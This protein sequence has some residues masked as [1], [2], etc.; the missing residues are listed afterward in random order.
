[1]PVSTERRERRAKPDP[2]AEVLDEDSYWW[3]RV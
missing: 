2:L 1:M 3:E